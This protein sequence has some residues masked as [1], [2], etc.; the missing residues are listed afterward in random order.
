MQQHS[1]GQP[2]EKKPRITGNY[3]GG[4]SSNY[5]YQVNKNHFFFNLIENLIILEK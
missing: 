5:E 1:T 3:T 2:P 4:E